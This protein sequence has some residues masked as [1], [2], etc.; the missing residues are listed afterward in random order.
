MT[1][2][3]HLMNIY[4]LNTAQFSEVI[5]ISAESY[6][7]SPLMTSWLL[8]RCSGGMYQFTGHREA[9]EVINL[10]STSG[11]PLYF[12][13]SSITIFTMATVIPIEISEKS[14]IADGAEL[15]PSEERIADVVPPLGTLETH[16]RLWF[17][18]S[19]QHNLNDIA[20]Q[21]RL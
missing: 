16:K 5:H 3:F 1:P 7:A 19:K 21:V 20:T 18:R 4:G 10:P 6:P 12:Q 17:Q 9:F 13:S 11:R 2:S 8:I 15:G 14:V